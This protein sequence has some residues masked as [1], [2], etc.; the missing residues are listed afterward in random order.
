M[1]DSVDVIRTAAT[2]L[3]EHKRLPAEHSLRDGARLH[4]V[5]TANVAAGVQFALDIVA[6]MAAVVITDHYLEPS[7]HDSVQILGLLAYAGVSLMVLR[8]LGFYQ[9]DAMSRGPLSA[10]RFL[11]FALIDLAVVAA[12]LLLAFV[13]ASPALTWFALVMAISLGGILAGRMLWTL[14]LRT[15]LRHGLLGE[16]VVV[17]G[18]GGA[19]EKFIRSVQSRAPYA[20][21][22]VVG[23]VDDRAS[24]RVEAVT[25]VPLLG[26][27]G[28]IAELVRRGAIQHA[29]IA[30]PGHAPARFDEVRRQLAALPVAV[31]LTW[32]WEPPPVVGSACDTFR[33]EIVW[34]RYEVPLHRL[35]N[36]PS[37][38]W[39]AI[40]KWIEDKLLATAALLLL[41]PVMAAI[42]LLIRLDSPGPVLFRQKRYGFNQEAI[43]VYKFRTMYHEE[44]GDRFRQATKNDSRITP[45]GRF[46]RKTSLDELPQLLNVIE[47]RMSLVGPRPHPVE[48][49]DHFRKVIAG[50]EGRH[51]VKPGI[52]G[53]AQI[54]GFRGETDTREKMEARI[55]YDIY[56]IENWSLWFDLKILVKT[57]IGG[58]SSENA[59]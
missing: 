38:G 39:G 3:V 55:A 56:Y 21:W 48:L 52:T 29:V 24:S 37:F 45:L 15:G 40:V 34:N 6:I 22:R 43:M 53:W 59:Y 42:A 13:Q 14:L 20:W 23:R 9:V 35:N 16:N 41:S 36:L 47:G 17:V 28:D 54:N 33:E 27:T 31:S 7:A 19:A 5:V 32:A 46:L 18:G 49:D 26:T 12:L 25:D 50:L 44:S 10:P 8:H 2:K 1:N 11:L 58:W 51:R 30:L 57:A 4:R